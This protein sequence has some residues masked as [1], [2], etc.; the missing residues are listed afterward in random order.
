VATLIVPRF[1]PDA[2]WPS[3]GPQI[4]DFIEERFIFGPGSLLGEPA[5]LDD[6]KRAAI[7][8]FYE[9]YPQGHRWAGR[10]R[11]KRCGYS[12][13]KGLAKTELMA[14]IAEGE[15][16]PEGP[17]RCDGFDAY[18]EP[19]GRPVKNPYIPLLAVTVEQVE[20]LAY[21]ALYAMI[22]E[23]PDADLFD[24]T[25]ERIVRLGPTG[26]ADGKCVPLSNSPGARDGART[27]F[28]GFDE[29]HRLYLPRARQAHETMV[30]NLSKRVLED[31]WG[32]YVGTAGE[33]GQNSIAE[34]QHKEAED[35]A[36]GRIDEPQLAYIC[37]YA[38]PGY[39]LTDFDQ[40]LSA[41]SEATGPVGEY[42][43]GQ[44]DDIA[45]QWDRRGADKKY[46]ERVWLNRW[47]RSDEQAFDVTLRDPNRAGH[48]LVPDPIKRGSFVTAGFDGARR[49]DSTGIV[50]TDIPTGRQKLWAVW[51][52]PLDLAEDADWEIDEDEVTQSVEEL[53]ATMDVWRFN[54]D[55]PHWTETMG[56]WAGRWPS[57]EEWWTNRIKAMAYAVR[58][59]REAMESRAVTFVDDDMES[60]F[61]THMAAAGRKDTDFVDDAGVKLFILR[62]I[63]PERRFDVQMAAVLSWEARLAA[64]KANA[65][66]RRRGTAVRR[67]R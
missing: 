36:A 26:R 42:G 27:T 50:I 15:L 55:P 5:V 53:H 11:F 60:I 31:P 12:V 23:G 67:L 35:I 7:Y 65:Q 1:D 9:V 37:R 10:R 21:G 46:L 3:L 47:T 25:L 58:G 32:L 8:T 39:D 44:F 28:Q 18:G 30:G 14:W 61:A 4:C 51:E 56:S 57:V 43:P 54:G 2:P 62:K 45:K 34:D 16:H 40:R 29:P 48:L 63:H 38:G 17:V 52:R 59:Y 24:A 64:L 19:V 66:P 6:D 49:R 13:R 22:T 33:P 20:E 41:V